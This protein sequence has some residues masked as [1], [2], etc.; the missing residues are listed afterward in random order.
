M[1]ELII[2]TDGASRG[3]PGA[4]STGFVIKDTTEKTVYSG[5]SYLGTTT[6]NVAEYTAIIEA[7]KKA[8]SI[9][10][11][12]KRTKINFY[13]D[14]NLAVQQLTGKFKVKNPN[15]QLLFRQVK[16]LEIKFGYV[17][18]RH[19]RREQN[20]EADSQA[21]LVLDNLTP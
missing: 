14:S 19:V 20:Q 1:T 2:F 15:L 10:L 3:N 16:D 13:M 21:N 8:Y 4:A 7:F 5:G 17:S 11:D 12:P 9:S 18:Y 6:N